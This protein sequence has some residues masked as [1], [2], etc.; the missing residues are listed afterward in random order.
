[1]KNRLNNYSVMMNQT[2]ELNNFI[3][4]GTPHLGL[5]ENSIFN[6]FRKIIAWFY[7]K[8]TGKDLLNNN[9]YQENHN[10]DFIEMISKFKKRINYS[11]I[12]MDLMVESSSSSFNEYQYYSEFSWIN[13]YWFKPFITSKKSSNLN[14]IDWYMNYVEINSLFNHEN[15]VGI[16]LNNNFIT[17]FKNQVEYVLKHIKTNFE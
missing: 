15:L 6:I 1:M 16:Y 5:K 12:S 4:I 7:L 13:R 2:I 14:G 9:N 10:S 11:L 8:Q 17:P 3:T